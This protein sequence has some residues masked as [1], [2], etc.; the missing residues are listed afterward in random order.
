MS[1]KELKLKMLFSH[2]HIEGVINRENLK[3]FPK[4]YFLEVSLL[5]SNFYIWEKF[6]W[7]SIPVNQ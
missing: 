3:T 5:I 4:T 7:A 6:V 2:F 1:R